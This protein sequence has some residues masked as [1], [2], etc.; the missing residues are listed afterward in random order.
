MNEFL[1]YLATVQTD[2]DGLVRC[3][4]HDCK[5]YNRVTKSSCLEVFYSLIV[6]LRSRGLT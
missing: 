4:V 1:S 5:S 6:D 3:A 2:G